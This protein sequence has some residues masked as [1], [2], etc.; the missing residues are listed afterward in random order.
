MSS[1]VTHDLLGLAIVTALQ[2]G[3]HK[4]DLVRANPIDNSVRSRHGAL[5]GSTDMAP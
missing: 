3:L 2:V 5:L 4:I 1:L